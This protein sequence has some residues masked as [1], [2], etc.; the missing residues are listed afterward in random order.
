V[1]LTVQLFDFCFFSDFLHV[2]V[3]CSSF[4]SVFVSQTPSFIQLFAQMSVFIECI[5]IILSPFSEFAVYIVY[6]AGKYGVS[7]ILEV[8]QNL[9]STEA[10]ALEVG[11]D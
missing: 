1:L 9:W 2:S 5:N 6:A 7:V 11:Y 10:P 4:F 3:S 8:T